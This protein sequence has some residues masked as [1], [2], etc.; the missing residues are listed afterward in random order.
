MNRE[1][2]RK[3]TLAG[4]REA[5]RELL[6]AAERD[7]HLADHRAAL[8]CLGTG[9]LSTL[10]ATSLARWYHRAE[11]LEATGANNR[12]RL[13]ILQHL[14]EA[15]RRILGHAWSAQPELLWP[16]A[17]VRT[18]RAQVTVDELLESALIWDIVS[19]E[20]I[21]ASP[22]FQRHGLEAYFAD[23]LDLL[24]CL[25][26]KLC[27]RCG[28]DGHVTE[29]ACFFMD[30]SPGWSHGNFW[31]VDCP[32]CAHAHECTR[33]SIIAVTRL[34]EKAL[35]YR[36]RE[37]ER[38][39]LASAHRTM[40]QVPDGPEEHMLMHSEPRVVERWLAEATGV[41]RCDVNMASEEALSKLPGI[42]ASVAHAIVARREAEGHFT[43]IAQLEE[44]RGVGWRTLEK[45]QGYITL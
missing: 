21:A 10:P 7:A 20:T 12:W 24:R 13:S 18:G 2:L 27:Q 29:P 38:K 39:A 4:E 9:A 25:D 36:F 16:F 34:L 5:A 8:D 22:F 14:T 11:A 15:D 40:L 44:A 45:I 31:Y 23:H 6:L 19:H 3:L 41:E 30:G 17:L 35:G 1:R 32:V 26:D 37:D 33:C 43:S 28:G 42:R